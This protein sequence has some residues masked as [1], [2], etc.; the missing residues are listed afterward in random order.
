MYPRVDATEAT[1]V[2]CGLVLG[3]VTAFAG[4]LSGQAVT[5]TITGLVT[6]STNAAISNAPVTVKNAGTGLTRTV[7]TSADGSYTIPFLPVGTYEVAVEQPGFQRLGAP[8][9]PFRWTR[10]L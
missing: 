2:R 1:A 5:G 6:D 4:A 8:A 10:S 9:S 3:M 7:Q